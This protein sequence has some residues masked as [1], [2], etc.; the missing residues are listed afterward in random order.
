MKQ[1]LTAT[2]MLLTAAAPAFAGDYGAYLAAQVAA[3][4]GDLA[5]SAEQIVRALKADP[6]NEELQRDAFAITLLAGRPEAAKIGA[7]LRGNPIAGLLAADAMARAGDWRGAELAYAELPKNAVSELLKPLLMAWSQQARGETDKALDT[8][9][10]AASEGHLG[11]YYTLHAA[12]IADIGHRDGEAERLY[13]QVAAGITTQNVRMT[14]LLASWQARS[15]HLAKA[16][17]TIQALVDADPQLAICAPGLLAAVDKPLVSDAQEGIAEAY[18]GVAGGL[19]EERL[20]EAPAMLLQLATLMQPNMTEARLVGAEMETRAHHYQAAADAL[21][22]VPS[23]DPLAAI[24][25]LRLADN[26]TRAG[27]IGD[28]EKILTQ[29][30]EAYPTFSEPLEQLGSVFVDDKKYPEAVA[31]YTGAVARIKQPGKS[32]WFLFYARGAAY[33]RSHD[34]PHAE[35]DMQH[36]LALYPDQPVVLN[37][38]GYSWTEQ[39]H[40]LP[41]ARR[42]IQRALEERPDDS[43]IMDSLG[44]VMLRQG[45]VHDAIKMLERAA[46]TTPDEATVTGHLGDA[47]WQ[48]GRKDEAEDQ[49]RRA[50]VLKPDAEDAARIAARLKDAAR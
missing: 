31:A 3:E 45:E 7:S 34:W 19:R 20:G 43:A 39:N 26:L 25:Q 27:K 4:D 8:L 18:A 40:N 17:A 5:R 6:G 13:G 15:G 44:W 2:L 48:A 38:L 23:D 42:M 41:E 10:S 21:A 11:L 37:F 35:A 33:E 14:Q 29:L 22:S 9:Q 16:K 28:A 24:V 47:Y 32:D 30:G 36:A 46:E 50:L 12:L 1:L 49:W